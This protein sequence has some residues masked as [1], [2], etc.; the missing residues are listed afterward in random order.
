ML[1]LRVLLP[2]FF[3]F[4]CVFKYPVSRS[5][6][7]Q[8][9]SWLLQR[10][11]SRL[12][13]RLKVALGTWSCL[14]HRVIP[15]APLKLD[16]YSVFILHISILTITNSFCIPLYLNFFLVQAWLLECNIPVGPDL[17]EQG[18]H[19]PALWTPH[20]RLHAGGCQLCVT[21]RMPANNHHPHLHCSFSGP[22]RFA[23]K[24]IDRSV[25]Q[26]RIA[27]RGDF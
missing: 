23:T 16:L 22:T 14:P 15:P 24:T 27:I 25:G 13:C 6:Y 2:F 5:T 9:L 17:Y 3:F 7:H 20:I 18:P 10:R 11:C 21:Q 26:I 19:E 12:D 1:Q 8:K 4:F